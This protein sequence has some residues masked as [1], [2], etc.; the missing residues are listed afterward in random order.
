[1][2]K[3]GH[4]Y[5]QQ[6]EAPPQYEAPTNVPAVTRNFVIANAMLTHGL[7]VF[8]SDVAYQQY[9]ENKSL[10]HGQSNFEQ[11]K[12]LQ[13][14]TK[15][16]P[17]IRVKHTWG[18]TSYISIHKCM[19]SPEAR[20]R[21]YD[22]VDDVILAEVLK[23]PFASYT[24]YNIT[25]PDGDILMFRHHRYPITD[26]LYGTKRFRYIEDQRLLFGES[27]FQYDLYLLDEKQPS[28]V[29]GLDRNQ[30][31]SLNNPLV[32]KAVKNIFGRKLFDSGDRKYIS[33]M[34]VGS[35]YYTKI[36]TV[37]RGREQD[38]AHFSLGAHPGIDL[39]SNASV[40]NEALM[41]LC[42]GVVLKCYQDD[43]MRKRRKRRH[44]VVPIAMYS[45]I[46]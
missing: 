12:A 15:A 28:L 45:S 44:G 35:L 8:A 43:M 34:K 10:K 38:T 16:M 20:D 29:D 3:N 42:T 37:F 19:S 11:A 26:V 4:I 36:Q 9:K 22:D 17:L 32:G 13:N 5:H 14:Q 21:L 40:D 46:F 24:R 1:M 2:E 27:C 41:L 18:L 7:K 31:I 25:T 30:E 39:N 33:S 23:H 6:E